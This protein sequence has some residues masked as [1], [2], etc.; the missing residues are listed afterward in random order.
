M[1]VKIFYFLYVRVFLSTCKSVF[2]VIAWGLQKPNPLEPD[3]ETIV[4][5]C[6]GAGMQKVGVEY[7]SY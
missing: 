5:H 3:L 1:L 6:V 2:L 7:V 4:N